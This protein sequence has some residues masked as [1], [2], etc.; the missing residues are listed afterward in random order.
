[1][2]VL[3]VA[4]F[5][6]L[7]LASISFSEEKIVTFEFVPEEL[8]AIREDEAISAEFSEKNAAS[9]LDRV[10][11][12]WQKAVKWMKSNQRESGK[13]FKLSPFVEAQNPISNIGSAYVVLDL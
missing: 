7:S 10:A 12:T 9:Y 13:W 1:M 4:V 3:Q 8:Q 6:S 5:L 11:L 2:R